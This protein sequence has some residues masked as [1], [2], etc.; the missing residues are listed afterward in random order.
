M[1]YNSLREKAE[2]IID[3]K[4]G[5]L[6]HD[7]AYVS[8]FLKHFK[9]DFFKIRR[10]SSDAYGFLNEVEEYLDEIR[11]AIDYYQ[12]RAN[13]PISSGEIESEI[14]NIQMDMAEYQR[15]MRDE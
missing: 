7:I 10:I 15:E 3:N 14:A 1:N 11:C 9:E 8:S 4:R 13:E 12:E 6:D 5:E 2:K